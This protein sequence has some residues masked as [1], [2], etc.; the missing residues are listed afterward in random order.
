MTT[1][2]LTAINSAI[3]DSVNSWTSPEPL[4]GGTVACYIT[5]GDFGVHAG[6]VEDADGNLIITYTVVHA[7]DGAEVS[8]FSTY[9]TADEAVREADAEQADGDN[10][11]Y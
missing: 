10:R 5:D 6:P 7:T 8:S 3:L 4:G 9:G 2:S 11:E 1:A